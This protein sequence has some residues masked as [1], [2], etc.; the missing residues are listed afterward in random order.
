MSGMCVAKAMGGEQCKDQCLCPRDC[1]FDLWATKQASM[2]DIWLLRGDLDKLRD[3]IHIL[4]REV[5][6][7]NPGVRF[8]EIELNHEVGL[9]K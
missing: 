4:M 8:D 3:A 7:L 5:H 6:E 9:K 2:V 1:S